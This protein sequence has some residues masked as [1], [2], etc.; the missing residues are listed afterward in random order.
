MN[1][2]SAHLSPGRDSFALASFDRSRAR[3]REERLRATV[4]IEGSL[5]LSSWR[6]RSGQR[7]VVGI[8]GFSDICV[9]DL[10]GAVL[11]AVRRDRMGIARVVDVAC[12]EAGGDAGREIWLDAMRG[13]G[14]Q[15][16]HIHLLAADEAE[17][18]EIQPAMLSR[19]C[20]ASRSSTGPSGTTPVGLIVAWLA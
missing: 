17:R 5:S 20:G 6:G 14:A 16:V 13:R 10:A 19:P 18:S 3:V 12:G 9:E 15:E 2:H 1:I 4:G 11:I 8:H 7:Y